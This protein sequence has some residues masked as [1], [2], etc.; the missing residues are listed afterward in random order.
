[1]R[2]YCLLAALALAALLAQ[3]PIEAEAAEPAEVQAVLFA[4]ASTA[5]RAR[6]YAAAYGRFARL[7]DAGHFASAQLA[8]VMLAQG[9][10]LFGSDWSASLDQR[11]RWN[12]LVVDGLNRQVEGDDGAA[13]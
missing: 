10:T 6:N 2:P 8:L 3:P 1:M 7:A 11:R 5:F 9:R 13:E 4:D 12:A